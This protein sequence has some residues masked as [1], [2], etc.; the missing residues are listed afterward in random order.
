VLNFVDSDFTVLNER[1]AKHYGIDGVKG[2]EHSRV[3]ELPEGCVRG[4]VLT[5][6]SVLKVTANG[7]NTSPVMRGVWVLRNI[8][9]QPPQPPPAAVAAVEPDIRGAATI[10]EQL[11]KHRSDASCNRCHAR[12]DPPGFALETFDPIG[13][14]RDRYRGTGK[15][16][17]LDWVRHT[18]YGLGQHVQ[19][20]GTMADGRAFDGFRGFRELLLEDREQIARAIATKLL[21]Y[22]CGRPVTAADRPVIDA[23]VETT[24]DDDYGLRSMIHAVVRSEMFTRP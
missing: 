11:Q 23:V 17:E 1:L 8:L 4:G 7:T 13:A 21:V 14:E 15:G 16:N 22:G 2:H 18:Q 19:A 3:V 12:I 20:S 5:H 10:R 6:A 9:G 24:A